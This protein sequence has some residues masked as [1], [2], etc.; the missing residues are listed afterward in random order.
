MYLF[1]MAVWA[2]SSCSRMLVLSVVT[3]AHVYMCCIGVF[4]TPVQGQI[5]V[6]GP[7]VYSLFLQFLGDTGVGLSFYALDL[8]FLVRGE[9]GFKLLF[10]GSPSRIHRG[11]PMICVAFRFVSFEVSIFFSI[12]FSVFSYAVVLEG[13]EF[14]G[15]RVIT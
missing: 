10:C 13:S 1:T 15:Q 4:P 11:L 2:I 6:S 5:C 3:A 9:R 8:N 12:L 14:F 7:E